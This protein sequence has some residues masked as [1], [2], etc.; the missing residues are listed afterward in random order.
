MSDR[1]SIRPFLAALERDGDLVRV[2]KSV[3][4]QFVLSAFLSAADAGPALIF[5]AVA[6]SPRP[7]SGNLLN[8]RARIAAAFGNRARDIVTRLHQALRESVTPLKAASRP[9]P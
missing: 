6:G 2:T 9:Q 4:R 7:V 3:D 1:Q 8:G 5:E